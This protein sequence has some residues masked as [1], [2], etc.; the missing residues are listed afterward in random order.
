MAEG[1]VYVIEIEDFLLNPSQ[2]LV[3]VNN[4]NAGQYP[5]H[6]RYKVEVLKKMNNMLKFNGIPIEND[7]EIFNESF[8][9]WLPDDGFK[10]ISKE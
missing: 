9:G 7:T 4:W 8:Y 3:L 6:K 1:E 10:I 2:N 5:T